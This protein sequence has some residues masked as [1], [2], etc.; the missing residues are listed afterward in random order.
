MAN[1]GLVIAIAG[2]FVVGGYAAYLTSSYVSL[3]AKTSTLEFQVNQMQSQIQNMQNEISG[4]QRNL[5]M[6]TGSTSSGG[7]STS[8]STEKLGV[9]VQGVNTINPS[10]WNISLNGANTGNANSIVMQIQVNGVPISCT[11]NE[12]Y[13]FTPGSTPSSGYQLPFTIQAGG[14]FY[15]SFLLGSGGCDSG[16]R[17]F[18]GGQTVQITVITAAG[19]NYPATVILPAYQQNEEL[20]VNTQSAQLNS[21]STNCPSGSSWVIMLGGQNTGAVTSSIVQI[22]INGV[23]YPLNASNA[24]SHP[25]TSFYNGQDQYYCM[26]SGSSGT[27]VPTTSTNLVIYSG[28]DFS[29]YLA[30]DSNTISGKSF[31]D[32]QTI[33]VTIITAA[34]NSYPAEIVLP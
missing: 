14:S 26:A 2:L 1:L 27:L 10:L 29:I 7:G 11:G 28:A 3:S 34:G 33:Q 32:G 30:L 19:N 9:L 25:F 20:R 24:Q 4:L 22:Q 13:W 8:Q 6:V 17:T 16:G 23:P 5:S 15:L 31:S 12:M 18:T 21:C